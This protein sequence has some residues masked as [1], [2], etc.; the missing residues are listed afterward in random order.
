[1]TELNVNA[2]AARAEHLMRLIFD[3]FQNL[4]VEPTE[5]LTA[6]IM[7]SNVLAHGLQV[8]RENYLDVVKES[9]EQVYAIPHPA[10]TVI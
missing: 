8:P 3:V 4:G 5:A 2:G 10:A 1:M 9:S 6:T 7:A